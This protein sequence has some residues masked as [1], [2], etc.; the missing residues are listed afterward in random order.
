MSKS[1]A[2][3][4]ASAVFGISIVVGLTGCAT[5]SDLAATG[6]TVETQTAT[7]V[8]TVE[9]TETATATPNTTGDDGP[10]SE[11][12]STDVQTRE[13]VDPE[14][15]VVTDIQVG[16][17]DGFD[18]VV[19]TLEGSGTPGYTAEFVDEAV[20]DGS[21]FVHD[22]GDDKVL[23]VRLSRMV[24]PMDIE[25]TEFAGSPVTGNGNIVDQ[26]IYDHWFEG[27]IR[28]FITIKPSVADPVFAVSMLD[29]PTRVVVDVASAASVNQ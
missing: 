23:L 6:E 11:N 10:S 22:T 2:A 16:T 17:H 14:D 21:G 12:W 26:V 3:R 28:S 20:Q 9:T 5:P 13:G 18:R 4:C 25:A 15:L 19:F 7:E 1:V 8:V 29:Q 27:G 24:M